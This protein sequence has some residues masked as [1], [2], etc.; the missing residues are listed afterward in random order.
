M[1]HGKAML[2]CTVAGLAVSAVAKDDTSDSSGNPY[3]AIVARNVFG[4][5]PPAPPPDP[6]ANKPPPPKIF[7]TGITTIFGNKRA[8]LKLTPP[9]KPGEPAKE[10]AFTL[11]EG[12]REGEL[13]V[14]EIDEKA[15]TVKVNDYGTVLSLNFDDNG[16]KMPGTPAPGAAPGGAPRPGFVPPAAG[17][18][19]YVP[20]GAAGGMGRPMRLPPPVGAAASP[21]SA[22]M[23]PAYGSGTPSLAVGGTSLPLNTSTAGQSQLGRQAASAP[24]SGLSAE[25]Q[26]LLV[27]AYREHAK[28]TG[29]QIP[30]IPP[31]PLSSAFN[32]AVGSGTPAAGGTTTPIIP[33]LPPRAPGLPLLL[34]PTQ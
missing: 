19:P 2:I 3:Q 26:F 4:L 32:S 29:Q 17:A 14:L 15:G 28:Q 20:P 11:G 12:Q 21:A 23:T 33:S 25:E 6:E 7:L 13:E 9:A 8:L 24:T 5:K 16:I 22:G 34:P 18:N 31:T 27:E 10:E 1:K 30:P